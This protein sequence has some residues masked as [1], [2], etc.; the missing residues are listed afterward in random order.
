LPARD[1]QRFAHTGACFD[2]QMTLFLQRLR[3]ARC[4]FL[5][6]RAELEILSLG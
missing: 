6:L 2:H 5:L 1:S 4:H 3:Y